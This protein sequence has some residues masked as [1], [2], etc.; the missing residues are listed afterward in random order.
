MLIQSEFRETIEMRQLAIVAHE[1]RN[2]LA[3]AW[4][5]LRMLG[6]ETSQVPEMVHA[7]PAIERQLGYIARIVDDLLDVACV[8][9]GKLTLQRESIDLAELLCGVIHECRHRIDADGHVLTVSMLADSLLVNADPLRLTQVFA[10]LLDNA[11]KYSEP[12]GRIG[13]T[14]ERWNDTAVVTVDD[15]GVGIRPDMLPRIF[16]MFVQGGTPMTGSPR[17]IGVGLAI[18]KQVIE[19]H[20]GHIEARSAGIG[21]GTRLIVSIPLWMI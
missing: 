18:A 2:P 9:S 4:C 20:G 19:E 1:L 17:G 7:L 8:A 11:V 16:D 3:A 10:N 21:L 5:A 13:V 14:V 15:N 6:R 12:S